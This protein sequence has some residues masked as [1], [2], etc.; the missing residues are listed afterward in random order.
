MRSFF[1]VSLAV[2]VVLSGFVLRAQPTAAQA[3]DPYS[4]ID[5]INQLR[6]TNGLAP[7]E[8]HPA[9][10]AAAQGHSEYQASIGQV[11]HT[12]QGGSRP[13]DRAAAA[14]YGGGAAFSLSENIAGGM[15]MA[16]WQ[17][18]NIWQ[19]D[20]PH[21]QTML[22][23]NYTHIGAGVAVADEVVYY[24]ID[25]G[26]IT[27][28]PNA[29]PTAIP[30]AGTP[31]ATPGP[32]RTPAAPGDTPPPTHAVQAATPDADGAIIHIVQPGETL[33][34]IAEAYGIPLSE[35]L[36]LNGLNSESVIYPEDK[37]II[38]PANT[39]TPTDLPSVT[40]S[41]T[42]TITPTRRPTRTP[43][44]ATAVEGEPTSSISPSD[45]GESGGDSVGS[46]LIGAILLLVI[47]GGA[48]MILGSVLKRRG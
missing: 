22:G 45:S 20:A 17:A 34:T 39:P 5:T 48:M 28:E 47:A 11:T 2:L 36:G 31:S 37:L 46:F 10:M 12:G 32:T 13:S 27:G 26:N 14:G 4:L 16:P 7:L 24:T 15:D 21:L 41:A 19:G 30:G 44:P 40:P 1:I 33:I 42:A 8:A 43:D 29:N 18:V 35:L 6:A 25:V 38:R 9:L 3:G 23:A